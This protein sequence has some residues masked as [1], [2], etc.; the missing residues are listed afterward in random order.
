M[1]HRLRSLAATLVLIPAAVTAREPGG[2]VSIE[3]DLLAVLTLR[4]MPCEAVASYEQ[5]GESD[6]LV[7][8]TDGPRY[9][10][11]IAEGDRVEVEPR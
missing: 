2:D 5:L 9:R 10:I 6:Y 8:C 4:G 1:R 3:Q 7:V 11:F